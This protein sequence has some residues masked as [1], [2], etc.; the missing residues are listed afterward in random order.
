MNL[1][2]PVEPS[3]LKTAYPDHT[4]AIRHAL[5]GHPLFSLEHIIALLQ[6]MPRDRIEYNSGKAAISQDPATTPMVKLAPEE[7]IRRIETCNAWMVLKRVEGDLAYRAVLEEALITVARAQGYASLEDAGYS[8]IQGFIFVSSPHST[9]PFHAD[10]EDNFFVQIHGEKFF[11]VF[12]NTDRSI[13]SEEML[14]DVVVKHRNL[15][16]DPSFEPKATHYNLKPGDGIFVPYQWPHYVQTSDSYSISLAITWKSEEVRR[17]NDIFVVNS[18]LRGLGMAQLP[19]GA[20]PALDALK[21]AAIRS[22]AAIVEPLRRS[23]A[24]RRLVR[25]LALGK[26]ANYYYRAADKSD[27][28]AA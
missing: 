14:E 7:I 12:D 16:Y 2:E 4:F 26:N 3:A 19:P 11:H 15:T 18:M 13:A 9:T 22:V 6:S 23:E 8:D 24:V 21:L 20:Q 10:N 25:R 5:V 27:R 17:R 1:I 28:D